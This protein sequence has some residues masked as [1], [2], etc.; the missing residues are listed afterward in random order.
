MSET[1]ERNYEVE[2]REQGWLPQEEYKEK[3][4]H[5][6]GW[7][8]EET[9]VKRGE[10]ILPIVNAKNKKL[11]E[12]VT[13]LKTAHAQLQESNA[14]FKEFMDK[15]LER[16]KADKV[17]LIQELEALRE[18]AISEGDGAA[19]T[20]A[21]QKLTAVRAAPE[22]KQVETQTLH[23]ETQAWIAEN[24]WYGGTTQ[25]DKALTAL[26]DGFSDQIAKEQ[27]HLRGRAHLEE[28]KKAAM[29]VL[30]DGFENP[31]RQQSKVEEPG[32][33]RTTG[34]GRTFND[35]PDDAKA[36]FESFK[37]DIPGYTEDQYLA[38]Y[39]WES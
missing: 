20:A 26:V 15:A 3:F 35:L 37:R 28:C 23:P 25:K 22:K 30:P 2:A 34:K 18:K 39:D 12:E 11:V 17:R 1:A 36:A 19:F 10:E 14:K 7:S 27:P 13:G 8:D 33:K 32:S 9:F 31:N 38:N 6:R 5:V 4:G 24:S 29:A 16:E 21:D